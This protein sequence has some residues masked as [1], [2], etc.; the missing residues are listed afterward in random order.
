MSETYLIRALVTDSAEPFQLSFARA[1]ADS[2]AGMEGL[3][4]EASGNGLLLRAVTEMTLEDAA[5]QLSARFTGLR[6]GPLEVIFQEGPEFKEPY[7]LAE[8]TVPEFSLGNVTADLSARRGQITE[9][10]VKG[11][12]VRIQA[13]APLAQ[14][15][16]YRNSLAAMSDGEGTVEMVFIEYRP[17]PRP[18]P[19]NGSEPMAAR[20]APSRSSVRLPRPP[21]YW[22][23]RTV[24]IPTGPSI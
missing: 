13:E 7:M 19:P 3:G 2:L 10:T 23:P 11:D 9:V 20:R 6:V 1:A 8:V 24:I 14:L 17:V 16:G 5:R 4:C 22:P 12:R 18:T 21:I 15:L